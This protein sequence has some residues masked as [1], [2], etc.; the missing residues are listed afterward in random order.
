MPKPEAAGNFSQLCFLPLLKSELLLALQGSGILVGHPVPWQSPQEAPA[1]QTLPC[2]QPRRKPRLLF[3]VFAP[4]FI[5]AFALEKLISTVAPDSL[6]SC[7]LWKFAFK[8]LHSES[9]VEG[10]C[11]A[12]FG[13]ISTA[14]RGELGT[15]LNVHMLLQDESRRALAVLP[16]SHAAP[17]LSPR[18]GSPGAG[19]T[20]KHGVRLLCAS[21][22]SG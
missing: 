17:L 5:S 8:S 20:P 7:R 2:T 22:G 19:A 14:I 18:S 16:I 12:L 13:H 11:K 6:G 15:E 4:G 3:R 21:L 1:W 10:C 9:V